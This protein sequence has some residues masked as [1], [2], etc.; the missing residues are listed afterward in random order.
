MEGRLHLV[1]LV[2]IEDA[3]GELCSSILDCDSAGLAA[4]ICGEITA[5]EIE[6]RTE[7]V[8]DALRCAC[9]VQLQ[10]SDS[11]V[12]T[13]AVVHWG[14][15]DRFWRMSAA[16]QAVTCKFQAAIAA[17]LLNVD[18]QHP[19]L[20]PSLLDSCSRITRLCGS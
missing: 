4:V 11:R 3:T 18:S 5:G 12:F 17:C 8:N 19:L 2:T 16:E 15:S 10:G 13:P 1:A 20:S 14:R 9:G 7:T 6:D